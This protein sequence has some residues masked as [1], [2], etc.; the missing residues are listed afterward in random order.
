MAYS[1]FEPT[2]PDVDRITASPLDS[3]YIRVYVSRRTAN[4][5]A[6]AEVR[7]LGQLCALTRSKVEGFPGLGE[8]GVAE[9]A[10]A[11]SA[12]GLKFADEAPPSTPPRRVVPAGWRQA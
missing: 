10:E 2:L 9:L 1:I 3:R 8:R 5:L 6:R 11:L 7:Y 12:L 4:A